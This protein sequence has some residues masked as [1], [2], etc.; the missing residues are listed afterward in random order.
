LFL[1]LVVGRRFFY[2]RAHVQKTTLASWALPKVHPI[3]FRSIRSFFLQS[4]IGEQDTFTT[5]VIDRVALI[6]CYYK[7]VSG[8]RSGRAF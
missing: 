2:A 6:V 3:L 7:M 5:S 4:F 1:L 8:K